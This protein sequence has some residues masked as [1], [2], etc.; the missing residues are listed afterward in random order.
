MKRRRRSVRGPQ[1]ATAGDSPSPVG[2]AG[3]RKLVKTLRRRA[4]N[5]VSRR[6]LSLGPLNPQRRKNS[7]RRARQSGCVTL[8][9]L[10]LNVS[11]TRARVDRSAHR[12]ATSRR[13]DD[14]NARCCT[15]RLL[16]CVYFGVFAMNEVVEHILIAYQSMCPLDAERAADSRVKN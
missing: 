16:Q 13:I 14:R 8:A 10:L 15:A 6:R 9:F 1:P 12:R 11:T 5:V 4:R 7:A 3:Q 2:S